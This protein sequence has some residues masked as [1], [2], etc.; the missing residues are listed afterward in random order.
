[1]PII[2]NAELWFAKLDPKR[3]NAKFN[4]KNPTWEIQLRTTSK[5]QKKVWEAMHLPLK[6][7]VPD[8]GA[9]YWRVNLRKRS[10]KA[11]N[12]PALPVEVIDG[13]MEPVSPTSIGNGSIGHVRIYQYEHPKEGGGTE[14]A[15]ILMGIQLVKHIKYKAKPREDVFTPTTTET[16]DPAE[17]DADDSDDIPF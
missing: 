2:E 16:F 1:M 8:E 3:P 12:E 6:A 14:I 5:E 17:V 9:P 7:V 13:N 11:D 15:T 10:I 4:K